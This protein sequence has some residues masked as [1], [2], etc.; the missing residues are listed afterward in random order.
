MSVVGT[1]LANDAP[2]MTFARGDAIW[3]AKLDGS[4]PHKLAQGTLPLL[5]PDG[6]QIA[7]HTDTS[8]DNGVVRQIAILDLA[9]KRVKVFDKEIP[10]HN[11]QHAIWSPDGTRILFNIWTDNNWHVA[12]IRTDGS[13][14]AYVKKSTSAFDSWW[15]IC[16]AAD[17]HS[18]Y[19]QNLERLVQFSLDGRELKSWKLNNIFPHGSFS[20]NAT[21]DL[22][23]NG[24]RLLLEVDMDEEEFSSPDWTGPPPSLWIFDLM[25]EHVERV[26]PKGLLAMSGCWLNES[27]ILLAGQSLREKTPSISKITLG[28]G[29]RKI[30]V[31][32]AADPSATRP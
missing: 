1:A 8:N 25:T 16:W 18:F 21:I 31:R 26:T 9:T 7:F 6:K 23:P 14:F 13:D 15:S 19:T 22:S 2:L 17:G 11:C 29:A 28:S 3:I 27:E 30:I 20:S 10:S 4:E 12:M 5:S 32:N 24:K